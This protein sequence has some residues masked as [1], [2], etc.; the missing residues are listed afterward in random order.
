MLD[1]S[2]PLA[3]LAALEGV[4]AR[5]EP[6]ILDHEGHE[7]GGVAANVEELEAI[8]LDKRLKRG[9]GGDADAVAVGVAQRLAEG[10][11][12]LDVAAGADNLDDNVECRRR[13]LS[14]L[15]AEAGRDVSWG[16]RLLGLGD[17][18]L[19]VDDGG[20]KLREPATLG[21]DVNA[22]TAIA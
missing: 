1:A 20:E 8:L 12:G 14:G 6:R 13:R 11:K 7:L 15:T 21:A 5:H 9:V 18:D 10:D 2:S 3:H 22:D 17:G 19:S 16:K 4:K